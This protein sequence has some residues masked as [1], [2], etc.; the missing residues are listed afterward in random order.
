MN[1]PIQLAKNTIDKKDIRALTKWLSASATPQ[2]TKGPLTEEFEKQWAAQ[3][4]TAYSVM[5]N[6]GS[7]ANL[8][9]IYALIATERLRNK[10]VVVPALSWITDISPVIQFG[11]E[12]ILCDCN[13]A[14]L[15]VDVVMLEKIFTDQQPALLILVSVLGL[16]PQMAFI[17][18]LC[19]RHGVLLMLDNCEGLGSQ[20]DFKPIENYALF[21]TCSLYFG[22]HLSTIEGGM[23]CTNDRDLYNTLKMLRSHGWDRDLEHRHEVREFKNITPF[24]AMYKFFYPAFN[25]RSTDLN[26]FLGL[27]QLNK[28]PKYYEKRQ[29]NFL[30]YQQAIVNDYWKCDGLGYGVT[31]ISNLGYPVIHP[32]RNEIVQALMENN[33]E[34]RPLICGSMGNQPFFERLYGAV[35][36]ANA[37]VVDK[38]GFYVPNHAAIT[39]KDISI[40]S[41]IINNFTDEKI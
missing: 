37:S 25:V 6:S 8:I 34:V 13:M 1:K 28:A 9:G 36:L 23:I 38:F 20:Y 11:L 7:S 33:I 32:R 10:K 19:R 26:A 15:S 39:V 21:S 27:R 12:P 4:G 17:Q 22:H 30:H 5:V 3:I 40:I 29:E 35:H 2:L 18:D 31:F 24:D 16:V 41:K 14:D